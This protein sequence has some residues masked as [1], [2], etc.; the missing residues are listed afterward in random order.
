MQ[1]GPAIAALLAAG[2]L[3]VLPSVARAAGSDVVQ[4]RGH[5]FRGTVIENRP[6]VLVT[7]RL[8][9]GTEITAPWSEVVAI[10]QRG[11][12]PRPPPATSGPAPEPE[13][14]SPGTP[15]QWYGWQT[16]L[17]DAASLALLVAGAESRSSAVLGVSGLTYALGPSVVHVAH[18]QGAKGIADVLLR[19]GV[20]VAF[21]A[22]GGLIGAATASPNRNTEEEE[23]LPWLGG[24]AVGL[25]IGLVTAVSIDAALLAWEPG[26]ASSPSTGAPP[27]TL[28][29]RLAVTGDAEHGHGGWM[30]VGGAF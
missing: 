8:D 15:R 10:D 19:V 11:S 1:Q 26:K 20:P 17:V 12:G 9:D 14:A 2:A 13:P 25:A 29:P 16:L 28:T 6:N 30:G 23:V 4:V 27:L 24:A 21:A 18:G 7:I 22:A 5:T 3:G